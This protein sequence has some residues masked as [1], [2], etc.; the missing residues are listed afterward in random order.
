M[1]RL[2]GGKALAGKA[3]YGL[4]CIVASG[5][6]VAAGAGYYAQKAVDSIGTSSVLSGG[7]STGAMNILIMGLESRTYWNGTSINHH[8]GVLMNTG[9]DDNGNG[10]NTTNTLILL[11]IFAG[12][13]KAVGF[14]IPRDSYVQMVGTL[15]YGPKMSKIDNAYGYAMFQ[16]MNSDAKAHPTWTYAQRSILGNEAGRLAEVETVEA[17]TGVKI[18]KFA[19]LNLVGFYELAKAFNGIEVCVYPW[20][21]GSTSSGYLAPNGNLRDP[22]VTDSSGTHGS[23]SIVRAGIQ[24]L[25]PEQAL[26]FVRNRHNLPGGDIGRTYRQ[27]AVLDYVL[28]NLKTSGVLSDVGKLTTLVGTAKDY[29]AVPKGWNLVEFGGE[30][31]ALTGHNLSLTTLPTTGT[32]DAPYGIGSVFTV[33]VPGIQALVQ[34]A[35]STQPDGIKTP[36]P[37]AKPGTPASGGSK[38]STTPKASATPAATALPA[39]KVTVDVVNNGAPQGTARLVLTALHAKAGYK[40]GTASSPPVGT[41]VQSLTTVSYGAGAKV[42]AAAIAKYF[43][44]SIAVTASSSLPA[45]HVQVTLGVATLGVPQALSPTASTSASATGSP[46][47]HPATSSPSSSASSGTGAL[48]AQEKEWAAEAQ[49]KYGIPCEY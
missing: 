2:P 29:L 25:S 6:L 11:H 22:V 7:P 1:L 47:S 16:Q 37:S 9:T 21:G 14:S 34:Q 15:G 39:S 38:A 13:K 36:A 8:L 33:D 4:G 35:F 28:S 24:H 31:D 23:G 46:T 40:A 27:Q 42:N 20:R 17:L 10:G 32:T 3:L 5:I 30:M 43:G 12:G 18:D 45:D 26:A 44:P 48:T 49:A 41:P 19:E